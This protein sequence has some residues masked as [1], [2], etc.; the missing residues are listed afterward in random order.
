MKGKHRSPHSTQH[1]MMNT[2]SYRALGIDQ[3]SL[4]C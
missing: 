1:D 2:L 3:S 4:P